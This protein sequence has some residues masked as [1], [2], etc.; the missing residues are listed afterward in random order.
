MN[1]EFTDMEKKFKVWMPVIGK[2]TYPMT[3]QDWIKNGVKPDEGD[4]LDRCV[5]LQ[6]TGKMDNENNEIYEGDKLLDEDFHIGIVKWTLDSFRTSG[7]PFQCPAFVIEWNDGDIT[8]FNDSA[9]L[10]YKI[11]GNVNENPPNS[12]TNY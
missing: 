11:I 8:G 2:M 6:F 10:D 9:H 12:F 5:F 1:I 4:V 3:I 7:I